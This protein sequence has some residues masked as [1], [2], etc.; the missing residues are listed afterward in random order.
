MER[1]ALRC[2]SLLSNSYDKV[3]TGAAGNLPHRLSSLF[4]RGKNRRCAGGSVLVTRRYLGGGGS[5]NHGQS[6]SFFAW[7]S[8]KLDTHPVA[9]KCISAGLIS[10]LGNILA[11]A[12]THHQE[13]EKMDEDERKKHGDRPFQVNL[14]QVSRFAMLNV[15]FV[16]PVLHYWYNFINRVVPGQSLSRVLQRTFWDEFV[17]SPMY[18]PVFLGMLW[19]LE[20]SSNE[21][22]W[23]MTKSEVPSII[24]AEWIIWVP[25]MFTTFRYVPVKFQVLVI[26][27][28]GVAWQTF[29]AYMASNAH[30]K[31]IVDEVAEAVK[32]Q[33]VPM[34]QTV[35]LLAATSSATVTDG[36][37]DDTDEVSAGVSAGVIVEEKVFPM[38]L[39][40]IVRHKTPKHIDLDYNMTLD[41]DYE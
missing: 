4:A 26:N 9:T 17:F 22:I 6:S 15:A 7:Y 14:A 40:T 18:I 41:E 37:L 5:Y 27:V 1:A 24:V 38:V 10:S 21:N 19:K 23:K 13:L 33:E 2:R 8:K 39:N 35:P 3:F 25:T 11:Q 34:M 30:T 36:D 28:I 29:L 12:I 31:E 16:A 20:G 32:E